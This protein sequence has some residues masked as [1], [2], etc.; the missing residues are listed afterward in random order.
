MLG[1]GRPHKARTERKDGDAILPGRSC[2]V[3]GENEY[4]RLTAA[5]ARGIGRWRGP[6]PCGDA[7]DTRHVDAATTTTGQH[8]WQDGMRTEQRPAQIHG[9]IVPPVL[10]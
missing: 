4:P 10:R 5:I 3:R 2:Q 9:D 6:R 8:P 1:H 7:E